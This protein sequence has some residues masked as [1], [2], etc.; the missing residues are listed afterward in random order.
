MAQVM[1]SPPLQPDEFSVDECIRIL[2][3]AAPQLA[4]AR[5]HDRVF[6][7]CARAAFRM[8]RTVKYAYLLQQAASLE[9]RLYPGDT[10]SQARVLY[11]DPARVDGLLGL[12]DEGWRLRPDFHFGFAARGFTNTNSRL[13]ADQYIAYWVTRIPRLTQFL[14]DDW[15]HELRRLIDDG[16]FDPEDKPQFDRD[17]THTARDSAAPRPGILLSR[18]WGSDR[19]HVEDFPS[20]LNSALKQALNA[21]GEHRAVAALTPS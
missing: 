3:L 21:L 12:R 1:M 11:Q 18:G 17:F 14:R 6:G 2:G 7:Y 20:A 16:I 9:L 5:D 19:A 15:N 4:V 10:L 8:T 13:N